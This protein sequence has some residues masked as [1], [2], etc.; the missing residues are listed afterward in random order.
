MAALLAQLQTA[1]QK[2]LPGQP[3]LGVATPR[4]QP[5]PGVVSPPLPFAWQFV[6]GPGAH[7]C[8]WLAQIGWVGGPLSL[9]AYFVLS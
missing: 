5:H 3:R 9:F 4:V 8:Q 1:M 7:P 6:V 2:A